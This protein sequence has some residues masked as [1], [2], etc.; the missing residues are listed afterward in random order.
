MK[1]LKLFLIIFT[2]IGAIFLYFKE[3]NPLNRQNRFNIMLLGLDP[4]NDSLEKTETTDTIILTSINLNTAKVNLISLPRDLWYLPLNEKINQIYPQNKDNFPKIQSTFSELTGQ[5]IDKTLIITTQNLIDLVQVIGGIDVVLDKGFKDTKY[6]NPEYIK[7][8][9]PEIPIYITVEFQTGSI[10]LDETNVTQFVR[11]RHSTDDL[12]RIKRQQLLID[13]LI[14]KIKSTNHYKELFKYYKKE[15][16][17]NLTYRDYINLFF[18]LFSNI[19]NINLNRV[20]I[21][22]L[23]YHPTKFINKQW[24]FLPIGDNYQ[25]L[26]DFIKLAILN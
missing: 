18:R 7:N 21:T 14:N 16:K 13:A 8:P 9:V 1:I 17:T 26:Q 2:L 23:L 22:S 19:K 12:D 6:P 24:V 4:R 15:I 11:S 25:K 5:K 20:D 10:H 3:F